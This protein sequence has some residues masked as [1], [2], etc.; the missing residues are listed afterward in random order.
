MSK[1][2]DGVFEPTP[3]GR[4]WLEEVVLSRH[5]EI[6]SGKVKALSFDEALKMTHEGLARR[7]NQLKPE[8]KKA[9]P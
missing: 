3:E 1:T 7:R 9:N 5:E 8:K 2:T 4:V 6:A